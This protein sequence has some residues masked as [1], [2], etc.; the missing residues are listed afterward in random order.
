M[1]GW[2]KEIFSALS[3]QRIRVCLPE[4]GCHFRGGR[5]FRMAGTGFRVRSWAGDAGAFGGRRGWGSHGARRSSRENH[6]SLAIRWRQAPRVGDQTGSVSTFH[7]SADQQNPPPH[8][9]PR[10][11]DVGPRGGAWGERVGAG[12]APGLLGWGGCMRSLWPAAGMTST[13]SRKV[14]GPGGL[15]CVKELK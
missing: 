7:P 10:D 13:L 8:H 2:F 15:C 9:L 5:G 4:K 14:L 1:R 3:T 12:R 6:T 11:K